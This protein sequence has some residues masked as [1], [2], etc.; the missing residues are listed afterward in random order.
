MSVCSAVLRSSRERQDREA[1]AKQKLAPG[2][3]AALSRIKP[4]SNG[5][6]AAG[7]IALGYQAAA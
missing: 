2:G 1:P 7:Q 4:R 5:T 6:H 3:D